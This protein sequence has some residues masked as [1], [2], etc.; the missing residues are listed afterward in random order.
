M[1][2]LR[3]YESWIHTHFVTDGQHLPTHRVREI[4]RGMTATLRELG[5]VFG[6]HL[7]REH[8]DPGIRVVLECRPDQREMKLIQSRLAEIIASIP[9]RP[10][11]TA[12]HGADAEPPLRPA[13]SR[14]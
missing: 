8:S 4:E 14:A 9:R 10:P 11:T 1:K 7:E 5:I 2:I 3:V 6:I 13:T 12:V